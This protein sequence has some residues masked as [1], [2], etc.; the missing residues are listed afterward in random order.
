VRLDSK[1]DDSAPP[2][3][4]TAELLSAALEL[5][6]ARRISAPCAGAGN[7]DGSRVQWGRELDVTIVTDEQLGRR[8][9]AAYLAKYATKSP[10]E[11]GLLDHR[12][13]AGIPDSLELPAHLRNLVETAWHLGGEPELRELRMRAWAHTAGYRGHFLTKSRQFSTTFAALREI[14]RQWRLEQ[15]AQGGEQIAECIERQ[16]LEGVVSEWRFL[17]VGYTTA[18]DSWLAE[19]IADEERLSKRMAYEERLATIGGVE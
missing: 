14:R 5:A 10:E 1:G 12:L 13:R 9:A 7:S 8:R 11:Q 3:I 16:D 4:F 17:G 18:G 6:A 15:N 2:E 19:S